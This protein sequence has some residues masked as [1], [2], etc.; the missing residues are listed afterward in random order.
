MKLDGHPIAS[1]LSVISGKTY[2][3]LKI[4]YDEEFRSIGPGALL[5]DE[6][7]KCFSRDDS[8]DT[9]SFVTGCGWADK[10]VPEALYVKSHYI[11]N[12]TIKG[13]LG[14]IVERSKEYLR[15]WKAAVNRRQA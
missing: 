5:L 6:T 11:Y 10:W 15:L 4:G 2:N 1:Q 14:Y 8:I 3:M 7:V 13:L 9:I 12:G